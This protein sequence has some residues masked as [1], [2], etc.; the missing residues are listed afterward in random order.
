[1]TS[2]SPSKINKDI[3]SFMHLYSCEKSLSTFSESLQRAADSILT[4]CSSMREA[5]S[6]VT[7]T[8]GDVADKKSSM[9]EIVQ[10]ANKYLLPL[11]CESSLFID[12]LDSVNFHT[13]AFE[14]IKHIMKLNIKQ[15]LSKSL[16]QYLNSIAS[17]DYATVS[18]I[19]TNSA[20]SRMVK[21]HQIMTRLVD[22]YY[23][24]EGFILKNLAEYLYQIQ[25]LIPKLTTTD[26]ILFVTPPAVPWSSKIKTR[27]LHR[28]SMISL[29]SWQ[30]SPVAELLSSVMTSLAYLNLENISKQARESITPWLN[31][32]HGYIDQCLTACYSTIIV[33]LYI[34]PIILK[35]ILSLLNQCQGTALPHIFKLQSVSNNVLTSDICKSVK[36]FIKSLC[37]NAGSLQIHIN[38]NSLN[39]YA[40]KLTTISSRSIQS[41]KKHI[42][43]IIFGYKEIYDQLSRDSHTRNP[44]PDTNIDPD[45]SDI[46]V[47]F[48]VALA[49]SEFSPLDHRDITTDLDT[50]IYQYPPNSTE[51]LDNKRPVSTLK[52]TP[53]INVPIQNIINLISNEWIAKSQSLYYFSKP[54]VKYIYDSIEFCNKSARDSSLWNKLLSVSSDFFNLT[55][56]E[57]KASTRTI[58]QE[59]ATSLHSELRDAF[60]CVPIGEKLC[61]LQACLTSS[62]DGIAEIAAESIIV[63]ITNITKRRE[64]IR[65][66]TNSSDSMFA[67]IT[68]LLAY[69]HKALTLLLSYA[70]TRMLGTVSRVIKTLEHEYI[71]IAHKTHRSHTEATHLSRLT[72]LTHT[73]N[74]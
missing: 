54:F 9:E 19:F 59:F 26:S 8:L 24:V 38:G 7:R 17:G 37:T 35:N 65:T 13:A 69:L 60:T 70:S 53:T 48:N 33:V 4:Q 45:F 64:S 22:R 40:T 1:M 43:F 56:E 20:D 41:E 51:L 3:E 68:A 63:Y 36:P 44:Y 5:N 42:N 34:K 49:I 52:K 21:V 16:G 66:I 58:L 67:F 11:D 12:P 62:C 25:S 23:D 57:H 61:I 2:P 74:I 6:L 73:K 50:Y 39:N 10:A 55:M 32:I 27:S 15:P 31:T 29:A 71:T 46:S 28:Y 72:I 14:L 18:D 30:E 47:Q